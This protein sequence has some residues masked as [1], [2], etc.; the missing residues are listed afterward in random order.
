MQIQCLQNGFGLAR[1]FLES[2]LTLMGFDELNQFYFLELM[3]ADRP[4]V[5]RP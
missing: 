5:S 2:S 1:Q 3:L 4:R